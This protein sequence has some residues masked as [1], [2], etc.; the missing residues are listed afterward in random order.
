LCLRNPC[1]NTASVEFPH[2]T[3]Y[4][5]LPQCDGEIKACRFDGSHRHK[6]QSVMYAD[7]KGATSVQDF[8]WKEA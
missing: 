2:L 8:A 3:L 7:P 5:E 6:P 1:N 4:D